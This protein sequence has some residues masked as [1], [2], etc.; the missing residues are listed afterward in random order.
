[1]RQSL[2]DYSIRMGMEYLLDEWD[3]EKNT[4]LTPE[5]ISFGSQKRVFWRCE[6]GH[7]WQSAINVRAYGAE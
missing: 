3:A 1:M 4:P 7:S 2:R 5:G 6:K